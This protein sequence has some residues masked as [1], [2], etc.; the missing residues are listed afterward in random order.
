MTA[1]SSYHS[2]ALSWSDNVEFKDLVLRLLSEGQP[3]F[4]PHVITLLFYVSRTCPGFIQKLF[5][6]ESKIGPH[7]IGSIVR[8]ILDFLD[9]YSQRCVILRQMFCVTSWI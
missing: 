3:D 6:D 7:A 9:E 5:D 1:L 4:K 8:S 2:V